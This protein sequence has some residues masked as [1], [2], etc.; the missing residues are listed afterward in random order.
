MLCSVFSGV[1]CCVDRFLHCSE[2][3]IFLQ[4]SSVIFIILQCF[5]SVLKVCA[6]KCCVVQ[7]FAIYIRVA[8]MWT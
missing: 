2:V 6:V 3:C 5:F 7:Y 4:C 8:M 1:Q